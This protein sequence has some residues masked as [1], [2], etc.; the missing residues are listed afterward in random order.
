MLHR[1]HL[2]LALPALALGSKAQAQ[3]LA[4]WPS[5]GLRMIIP[6]PP[7]QA[8]DL[9]G[10]L[11]A[12]A[13]GERL[14]QTVVPENKPGAGGMIGTDLVAKAP[15]DGYMLLSA[16][17]GP[18][19][20]APLVQRTPY[21]PEKDLT[22]VM[23]FGIAPYLLVV[24]REFPAAD[25]RAFVALLRANP[26]KYSFASSGTGG[27]QHLVTAVFNARA[28]VETLHVPFQGS[29]AAM[30]ALL[31]GTVDYAIE[32]PAG[33]WNLVRQGD[34]RALGQSLPRLTKLLPGVP[35][36]ADSAGLPGYGIG[37][38]NGLMAPAGLPRP[39][40]D[41]LVAE[42]QAVLAQPALRERLE[43]IGLEPE[44]RG[45]EAFAALLKEQ[46][47]LLQPMI[48]QLGIRAE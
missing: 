15:A 39:V 28:A 33:A 9:I 32:T 45:P 29:G 23:A 3:P 26:G 27:S 25:A 37:G 5:R 21:D 30:A 31:S 2:A 35:T 41:R 11:F 16:S 1:R 38:W 46:K 48:R 44:P 43:Q 24:R 13:L 22:P 12:Q 36:L 17:G 18:V 6:W 10:R 40:L 20:F 8:T 34:L 14:G 42:T 19:T 4:T 7:G 47:E